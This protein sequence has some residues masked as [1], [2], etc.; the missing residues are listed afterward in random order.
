MVT[1]LF[2]YA[3]HQK[4]ASH[5]KVTSTTY[6]HLKNV[7]NPWQCG[8]RHHSGS[9][10]PPPPCSHEQSDL[11]GCT[12]SIFLGSRG[13]KSRVWPGY[14]LIKGK[15]FRDL[16]HC[17]PGNI[18]W[19]GHITMCGFK[20]FGQYNRLPC[21]NI[22]ASRTTPNIGRLMKQACRLHSKCKLTA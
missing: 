14:E 11:D 16:K 7:H 20:K 6:V 13:L 2:H 1:K 15:W 21:Y 10:D 17:S 18:Q 8:R 5:M 3:T 19:W 12:C 9:S 22:Q 4:Q